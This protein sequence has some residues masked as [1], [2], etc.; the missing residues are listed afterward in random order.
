M[1]FDILSIIVYNTGL[2]IEYIGVFV[3]ISAVVSALY[4]LFFTGF[5]KDYVRIKFARNVMFGLE[6]IIAG[7]ILLVTMIQNLDEA[8]KLGGVILIRILL[9]YALRQ[10][11][12]FDNK[13]IDKLYK[14]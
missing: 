12:L 10:E 4:W 13:K 9:G 7:D 8:L 14:K 2:S 6:F 1:I 11:F 3:V 5:S